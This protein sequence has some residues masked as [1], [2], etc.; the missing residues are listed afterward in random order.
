M[1]IIKVSKESKD[2]I[3][4]KEL[5][6]GMKV[7]RE[8]MD[9]YNEINKILGEDMPWTKEEFCEKIAR[10]HLKELKDYYTRLK[11]MEN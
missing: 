2:N 11:K 1:K 6:M 9:V 3:D 8:H 5:D 4:P 10:A 7:E